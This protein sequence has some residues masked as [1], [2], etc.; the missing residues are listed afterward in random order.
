MPLNKLDSIIKNTEGRILYVSPSDLDSTDSISNQGNSLARPFKTIQRALIESARFSYV[1]GNNNDET[2]KTTILLMPGNHVVDNRPGYSIDNSNPANITSADGSPLRPLPLTLDS[3]FDLTQKDNDLY[4]FNSVNGGVIVPRGTSI[5]GLDLRKTKIRPLYVPNPTDDAVPYSAIFRI[6]G[7][8]YLWQFSIFDGDEFGTVYTQHNN[9]ELKSSPTFS[10]HKLTVFE[11]ADGVNE[12]G[13]QGVT[14]LAM[15]YAKLSQA[16]ASGSGREVDSTDVFPGNKEGFTSVRPEFEIVG[17]FASDP[18]TITS[19]I[20]GDGLTPTRRITVTTQGPH[21]LDVGTPI[22]IDG[23]AG[24]NSAQY[25]ISTR[26]TEVSTISDNIF[27]YTIS[28]DP[29]LISPTGIVDS[30]PPATVTIETDTVSGASPYIFNISMRSVWGMNGMHTD[31]SKATGF[32]SMVVAQFTGVSLQ[33]DDRAFVK[34]IPSSRQ[35]ENTFY[36]AGTTQT[37]SDLSSKSSS[38]GTV[39]HLD[40]EAIYRKGWEQSHIKITNDAIVQIVSVFAIGYNKHF[41]AQSGGDASVT[42]SNSNFGQ[43]SLISEGFKK[44]A[45]EKDNKA[46]ITHIIPPRALHS[47]EEDIDWL[48]LDN[49]KTSDNTK[50]YL[51]GFNDENIKPPI[52]TQGYRVGAKVNDKLFLTVGGTEYSADIL[53]SDDSSSFKEYPVTSG[54]SSNIFTIGTHS[55]TTGEK[56]IIISDDGDLPENLRTNTVY[57]AI[58]PNNTTVKLAASKAEADADQPI[59]V[60]G[61]TNLKI[62]TRV[63]DKQSGDAGHPVQWDGSQWYIK[64][65]NNTITGQLSGT[66]ASEPTIIKRIADTR[67][68]D[69]KIYKVRVVVPSQLINAKTPEAGFVIQESST[70]GYVGTADTSRETINNTNYNWNRNPSFINTCSRVSNTVTVVSELPHNLKVGDSVTIKN[71]TDSTNTTGLIDKGYNGTYNVASVSTN[72]LEFTYTTTL[73]PGTFTNNV[74]E[75]TTSLPRFERTDLQSNL[76]VYRNEIISEYSDG[77]SNGVYH[78]YTLNSNNAIQ[79]EFT[80][81]EYSQNVTDLYPQLDRDNPNDDPNSAKTYALRSPI[82]EVQ[83]DDLKKSITRESADLLLTSLG[84]GLNIKSV[85]NTT[86]TLPIIEFDR[87]HNFNS[88]VTGSL[89]ATANFTPGTYY[90]VK[91]STIPDP[92]NS[93]SAFDSAWQGATAK[94]VVAPGQSIDSV[95]IMNGGSNYSAA[96]A[97]YYL[98]TRVIGAGTPNTFTVT[99]AGI[100]SHIGDVVQFTGIGTGTD[101]YHRIAS[102]TGRD[103]ISI[104]RTTGDPVITSDNYAFVTAPSVQI[105]SS[106]FSNAIQTINTNAAHGLAPGNK[107]RIINSSNANKGDFI[108]AGVVDYDTFTFDTESEVSTLTNGYILKHGLSSNAG[109][110]DKTNEN[111]DQRAITIFDGE[112]L[113]L[114]ESGGINANSTTTSFSVSSPGIAGT[115]TRFPLGSYIQIDNEIMRIASDSLSGT[116]ADQI[117]VIRGALATSPAIH[118]ENSTI[119]KVKVPSIEF[120]RPSIIRASGHTFEYLGYGPGNYSTGL[121]Q[122]QDR[123]LTEREEFLSQAQERGAGLVVYT[124]MNNKGDFY[125]GNQKKSSATGEE[126]NFDIPV[127]TV[128]GEDP[129]RL[130]AVFDE[131]TIKERLVVEGGDSGQVLSQFGGP[132]TFDEKIKANAQVKIANETDSTGTT[133][134]AL[135]VTGGVGIGK[136]ITAANATVGNVTLNGTTNELTSTSGNLNI[137]AFAGSSVA[138]QTNTNVTGI[139]DVNGRAEIDNIRIDGNTIGVVDTNG[140]ITIDPDGTGTVS[141]PANTTVTGTLDVTGNTTVTGTLGVTGNTTLGNERTDSQTLNGSVLINSRTSGSVLLGFDSGSIELQRDTGAYIDF[142]R[143]TEDFNVRLENFGDNI[144]SL[145]GGNFEVSQDSYINVGNAYVSSGTFTSSLAHLA[146]NAWYSGDTASWNFTGGVGCLYQQEGQNHVWWTHDGSTFTKRMDLGPTGNLSVTGDIIAFA[147]DERLKTNISPITDALFKVNSLNGFTY[148]FNE[149]GE[150]LG[151]NPDITY[152]G[153]SAQEVQKVLPEVVH[154]APVDD[155]YIT[156]QY[157]K[158]VPLLIE[159]IKEL[160]DK[161]EKLEQRLEDK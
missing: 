128:T 131:V 58:A 67:S 69:E 102:V 142:K 11:Y 101:T 13:T 36:S 55:L 93:G 47:I 16:Y 35:Y 161:V 20:S 109:V 154:P 127:P 40:S 34:Y 106:S 121:P 89:G 84:I 64:V 14:D 23:V 50:L 141:I 30:N 122:V 31:G 39:Y 91:I 4:K 43:L 83:T 146:T 117:T 115:M 151:F 68:L 157:D 99:S 17:A 51:F 112:T 75:R 72:D 73:T 150:K 143:G 44:E 46:F 87:N 37:G 25:N 107:F 71:V 139:L 124:G 74:N 98:D 105:S 80:N 110:S 28:S 103:S 100:S 132:V 56:V 66:G 60:Y 27:F 119:R 6:T 54:P 18:I 33:K 134:G 118:V 140:S 52:L 38:S 9:F 65:S 70:T 48:T 45:F 29:A 1:K 129:S 104:A 85:D 144:L 116:P 130:S 3:V 125:I 95:E 120:H 136:T 82:G 32:R 19:I 156:V 15:Y 113:T 22:N 42:N 126:T 133:S 10:H 81:L 149:I 78:I 5:V 123:T 114:S 159:A 24:P 90:N 59:T 155:K 92:I 88:I 76:Y 86:P 2:E 153:V 53:M 8:C 26:V 152:A 158:V 57:Y 21:G 148:K 79:N 96:T 77:D 138:I 12:V 63:S 147:S 137:N 62:I 108:V 135:V 41:E 7:A 94:V 145:T 97:T 111:L 160:S 49:S 61:G